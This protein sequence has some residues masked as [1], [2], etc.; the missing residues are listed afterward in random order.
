MSMP[1]TIVLVDDDPDDRE[2]AR[3]ALRKEFPG[4]QFEDVADAAT[5]DRTL[6]RGGFRLV[7][8]DFHL[9][10]ST[11]LEVLKAVKVN[12]PDCPVIMFTASGDEEIAVRAMKSGLDDY[13]IKKAGHLGRLAAAARSALNAA[14]TRRRAA[15][16][17]QRLDDLLNRLGVGVF[18]VTTSCE[19]LDCNPAFLRLMG[20]EGREDLDRTDL[21]RRLC[22][23]N[24]AFD[25]ADL[26]R[27][28]GYHTMRFAW[29]TRLDGR[30]VRLRINSYVTRLGSSTV[31]DG[32]VEMFPALADEQPGSSTQARV[33]TV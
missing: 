15:E 33:D 1:P 17:Q 28:H 24:G 20:A 4:W 9:C 6:A 21:L 3:H 18:R 29:I 16:L 19:L 14:E 8:T 25:P 2:L 22:F 10:W 12:A 7:I 30:V 32:L 23:P 11:G 13:V 5:L 27:P 31:I 26:L